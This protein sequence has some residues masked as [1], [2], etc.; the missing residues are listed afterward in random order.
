MKKL[1]FLILILTLHLS[2]RSQTLY[3]TSFETG[4]TWN[5]FE[6]IVGGNPCYDSGLGTVDVSN[7]V[8]HL[9]LSSLQIWSNSE[10][11]MNSNHVI[12]SYHISNTEGITG[13]IL[14]SIWV[15]TPNNLNLTQT[16]PEFSL[17]S[18]RTASNGTNYTYI[19]GVQYIGNQWLTDKWN[20]WHNG[21]WVAIKL[22]EFNVTLSPSTWYN[23][24]LEFDMTTN[25]YLYLRVNGGSISKTIDL[26][27]TYQNASGGFLIGAE[28]RG[29]TPSY[30][31]T[32]E[33]QNL[34]T[35]CTEIKDN[36]TYYDDINL[37]KLITPPPSANCQCK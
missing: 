10:Q 17:Q 4:L 8:A 15:Y 1:F 21:H 28:T 23:L 27:R 12:G 31:I 26:T 25:K 22:S 18:T 24:Q 9:G 11:A 32:L 36:I 19:A 37:E 16:G 35:N 2:V 20:I 33:C 13:K 7:S 6:E 3:R 30:F 5:I 14:Y 29:W 34:W